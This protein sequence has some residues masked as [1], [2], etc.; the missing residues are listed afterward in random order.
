V[1][2]LDDAPVTRL[3]PGRAEALLRGAADVHV[4]VVGDVM[5][6]R[7][8]TGA[9]ERISPEAPV[10]VVRVEDERAALG[11]AGN[12]AANLTALGARCTV[13]GC[14]GD[15]DGGREV[16]RALEAAGVRA[17]GL[18][19]SPGRPTTVK[20]RVLARHQQVVRFDREAHTVLPD[21]EARRMADAVRTLAGDAHVVVLEDYD[22]GVLAPPVIRAAL[23]VAAERGL[24]SVV[25]PKR[26]SFFS[27]RGATLFK[28]NAR[29][30]ADALGP[31]TLAG[32]PERDSP[33]AGRSAWG[34]PEWMEYVRTRLGCENL[35]VTLG[36]D[37]MVMCTVSGEWVRIPSVARA[38]Y[39]ISGAGDTVTAVVALV[40]AAGG[41]AIEAAILASHA[42][43]LEVGKVGV[44]TLGARELIEHCH[45]VPLQPSTPSGE[46]DT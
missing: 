10:P 11:G 16:R 30:L 24:P 32:D 40:L 36:A 20:T 46:N 26:R 29:E 25:D 8:V 22:K 27:F 33:A 44:A 13:A 35:L 9:V 1:P 38:V 23:E 21:D 37:G 12:V 3:G 2:G 43:A 41:T 6:D 42:A 45:T 34:N 28:P 4:L 15:D 17:D 39:D 14:V 5:L 18:V 7:Y 31:A 19:E